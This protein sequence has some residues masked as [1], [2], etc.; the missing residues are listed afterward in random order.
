MKKNR[1]LLPLTA[2]IAILFITMAASASSNESELAAYYGDEELVSIAT[3]ISQPLS[4]APAVASVI[5][6]EDIKNIGATDLDNVLETVPGLHV[7]TRAQGYAPIYIFRGVFSGTN[8][9]V[10]MLINGSPRTNLYLGDR[11][12]VWAG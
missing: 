9:Q 11:N 6:A 7:A 12:Q 10:L 1:F 8:P 2:H 5:T 4:K 3:G